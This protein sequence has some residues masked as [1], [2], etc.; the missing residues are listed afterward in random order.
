M[1]HGLPE[2]F[3]VFDK[4]KAKYSGLYGRGFYFTNSSSHASQYG[5]NYEVYLNIKNPLIQGTKNITKEQLLEFVQMITDND[6]Y[7]IENYGYNATVDSVV[8]D[9]F[10]KDDF[11]IILDINATCIGDM[12]GAVKLF[13]DVAGTDYDGIVVTTET[14]AFY[15]NQIKNTSNINPTSDP[16]IRYSGRTNSIQD[17]SLQR[18]PDKWPIDLSL[19]Q[20]RPRMMQSNRITEKPPAPAVFFLHLTA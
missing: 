11:S 9:I 10:G 12:V 13:N 4:N 1:Y 16:D 7:G 15:P 8:D 14:I 20:F 18:V 19:S 6:D 2:T 3:T 17:P 5:S